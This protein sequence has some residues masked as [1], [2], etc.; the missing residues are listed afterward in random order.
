M[1]TSFAHLLNSTEVLREVVHSECCSGL[2]SGVFSDL[3]EHLFHLIHPPS[4][5]FAFIF[6][7]RAVSAAAA[8]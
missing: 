7:R 8:P 3:K 4:E 2:P 1:S 5:F 6:L